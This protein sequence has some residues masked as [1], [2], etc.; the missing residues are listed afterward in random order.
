M[1]SC[2]SVLNLC[3]VLFNTISKFW[4]YIGN[5][6]CMYGYYSFNSCNFIIY[7]A[8]IIFNFLNKG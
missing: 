7:V 4:K 2:I 1:L 3:T 5:V 6:M 8:F